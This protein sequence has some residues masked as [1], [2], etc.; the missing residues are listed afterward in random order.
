MG[1]QRGGHAKLERRSEGEDCE[2]ESCGEQMCG[3]GSGAGGC[4]ETNTGGGGGKRRVEVESA[5]I[6]AKQ[7]E[8]RKRE[9]DD[10]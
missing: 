7:I 8:V 2:T 10:T 6:G 3:F 5:A 9:K 1:K 4:E